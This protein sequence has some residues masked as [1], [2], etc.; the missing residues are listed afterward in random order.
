MDIDK[1]EFKPTSTIQ[2]CLNCQDTNITFF[3][4]FIHHGIELNY[5]ICKHC[6]LIFQNPTFTKSQWESFYKFAYRKIYSDSINPTDKIRIEHKKRAEYQ[7]DIISHHIKSVRSHLD[8]GCAAGEL[9]ICIKKRYL[10]EYQCGIEPG[11]GYRRSCEE[12]GFEVYSSLEALQSARQDKFELI[13]MSHVI[14]HIPNPVEY[15]KFVV[16]FLL[17]KDGY[18]VAEVPNIR[19]GKSFEIAHPIC[20]SKK[21]LSDSLRLAGLDI[22]YSHLH[23]K[24]KSK[25]RGHIYYLAI[26]RRKNSGPKDDKPRRISW[27]YLITSKMMMLRGINDNWFSFLL[28]L[29]YRCAKYG[30]TAR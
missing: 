7:T 18:L 28:K 8:I 20:F 21:T 3:S 2:N 30:F 25:I 1:A 19:G 17:S 23:G 11:D 6:G 24:P 15:L 9:L 26:S 4:R 10:P 5:C 29:P 12:N 27:W 13:T 22:A 16:E 14:E